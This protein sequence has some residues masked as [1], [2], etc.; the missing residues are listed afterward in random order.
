MRHH[1][2]EYCMKA[3]QQEGIFHSCTELFLVMMCKLIH[4]TFS[5]LFTFLCFFSAASG[6][7][8]AALSVCFHSSSTGVFMPSLIVCIFLL[9]DPSLASSLWHEGYIFL[10]HPASPIQKPISPKSLR[11]PHLCTST[12]CNSLY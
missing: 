6:C 3:M 5:L 7:Y 9:Q 1:I 8:V 4:L 11:D 10:M 2:W 12:V